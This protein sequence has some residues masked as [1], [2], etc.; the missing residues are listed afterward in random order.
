MRDTEREKERGRDTGRGRSRLSIPG[1]QDHTLGLRQHQ[2]AEPL[3]PLEPLGLP[4]LPPHLLVLKHW[5]HQSS[6][7]C[8]RHRSF[9]TL[10][11]WFMVIV[12]SCHPIGSPLRTVLY[13]IHLCVLCSNQ[14]CTFQLL[15][16][17]GWEG[18]VNKC[19]L[20]FGQVRRK[21]YIL[22]PEVGCPDPT[23]TQR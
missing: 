13:Q 6:N 9:V 2:T 17:Y 8:L 18:Y 11:T 16:Q 3:E 20:I 10:Y 22:M 21:T 1:P 5:L 12:T 4:K 14:L 7:K 19:F 15:N 23:T